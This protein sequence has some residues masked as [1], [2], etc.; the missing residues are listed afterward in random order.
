MKGAAARLDF[1]KAAR[2]R[3]RIKAIRSG[4]LEAGLK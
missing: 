2:I 1:E 4:M 3:D